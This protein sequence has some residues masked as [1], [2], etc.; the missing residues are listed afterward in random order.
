MATYRLASIVI[1]DPVDAAFAVNDNVVIMWNDTTQA[2]TVEKNGA[3]FT[4]AGSLL[5]DLDVN[6]RITIGVSSTSGG[7]AATS[8]RITAKKAI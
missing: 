4:T 2:I 7:Y 8:A 5:G 3:S 1:T 6:Y